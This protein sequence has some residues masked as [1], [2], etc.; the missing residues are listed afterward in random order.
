MGL[1]ACQV[2][3][4]GF[5]AET[6]LS[7]RVTDT[8]FGLPIRASAGRTIA[9]TNP[10]F[11]VYD[12]GVLKGNLANVE[13]AD[14]SGPYVLVSTWDPPTGIATRQPRWPFWTQRVL[15]T[16]DIAL[17]YDIAN[18]TEYWDKAKLGTDPRQASNVCDS[19]AVTPRGPA[20]SRG[21]AAGQRV[22]AR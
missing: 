3:D 7:G 21:A 11:A 17:A 8:G 6:N 13:L 1:W 15:T 5:S 10:D 4:V 19:G 16:G 2:S 18:S 12:R 20:H 14:M 22:A 9:A